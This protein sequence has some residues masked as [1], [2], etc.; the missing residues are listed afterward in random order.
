MI[1]AFVAG[2]LIVIFVVA[3]TVGMAIHDI[4]EMHDDDDSR[5]WQAESHGEW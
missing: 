2:T 4:N 5:E 3:E 1:L